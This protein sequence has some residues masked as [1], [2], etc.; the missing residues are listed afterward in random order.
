M[1]IEKKNIKPRFVL[2]ISFDEHELDDMLDYIHAKDNKYKLDQVWDECFRP[3]FKHGY[4]EEWIT[5]LI[6][7]CGH[8]NA[9]SLIKAI[10]VIYQQVISGDR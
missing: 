3:M 2:T 9:Y 8:E 4:K 7:D 1:D 6:E 10:G 5:N